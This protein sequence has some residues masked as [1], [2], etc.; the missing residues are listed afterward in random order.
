MRFLLLLIPN[1][2]SQDG[3][4]SATALSATSRYTETLTRAGALLA[5]DRLHPPSRGARVSFRAGKGHVVDGELVN[6]HG[7][8]GGYWLLQVKSKE[9][10]VE[11][12]RR[13]PCSDGQTIEVRQVVELS[14]GPP[15]VRA[16]A[17]SE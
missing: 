14:D 8:I 1:V 15:E 10:A 6:P 16:A 5:F 3:T 13:C 9:E 2:D 11:W 7:T 4:V 17:K 12:A